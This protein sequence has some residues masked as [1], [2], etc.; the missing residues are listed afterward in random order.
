MLQPSEYDEVDKVL[1]FLGLEIDELCVLG[2]TASIKSCYTKF[3]D[4]VHNI[5]RRFLQPQLE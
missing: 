3:V 5:Y 2:G 1:P 4:L